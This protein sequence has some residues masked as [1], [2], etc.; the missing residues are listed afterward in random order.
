MVEETPS[1]FE[2]YQVVL[3]VKNIKDRKV[4]A[5]IWGNRTVGQLSRWETDVLDI[6]DKYGTIQIPEEA[7]DCIVHHLCFDDVEIPTLGDASS[8]LSTI[9]RRIRKKFFKK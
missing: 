7:F 3:V 1:T 8:D 4:I 2:L 6:K 9:F 5:E